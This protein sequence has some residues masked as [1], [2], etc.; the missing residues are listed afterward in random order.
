MWL[1]SDCLLFLFCRVKAE[2]INNVISAPMVEEILVLGYGAWCL[3]SWRA[4]EGWGG[5]H[6][7]YIPGCLVEIA[8]RTPRQ[9]CRDLGLILGIPG[10][11]RKWEG[12]RGPVSPFLQVRIYKTNHL[13]IP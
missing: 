8:F 3:V 12:I 10:F 5:E 6:G 11:S 2:Y 7:L 1:A 13:I 4:V 9:G